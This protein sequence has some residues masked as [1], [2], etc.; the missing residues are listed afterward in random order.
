MSK[1][2]LRWRKI[3]HCVVRFSWSWTIGRMTISASAVASAAAAST[4]TA[5]TTIATAATAATKTTSTSAAIKSKL[6]FAKKYLFRG[7]G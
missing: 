4:V 3:V 1:V 7:L 5:V 2:R 6:G